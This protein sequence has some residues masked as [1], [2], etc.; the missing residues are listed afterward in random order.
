MPSKVRIPGPVYINQIYRDLANDVLYRVVHTG[1]GQPNTYLVRLDGSRLIVRSI[2]TDEF[3]PLAGLN[4]TATGGFVL[5][6]DPYADLGRGVRAT[7]AHGRQSQT[8][9][10]YIR[11]L[12][13]RDSQKGRHQFVQLL[14][15]GAARA[16]IF[17]EHA[18]KLKV[19]PKTLRKYFLLW[20]Q[21]GMTPR[22]VMSS[23][24]NSGRSNRPG[25]TRRQYE[26]HP[27]RR[28]EIRRPQTMLPSVYRDRV[29]R[30]MAD[31]YFT[32]GQAVWDAGLPEDPKTQSAGRANNAKARGR[33]AA[34]RSTPGGRE[35][36]KRGWNRGSRDRPTAL[37]VVDRANYLLRCER[38]VKNAK[39]EA[40]AVELLDHSAISEEIFRHA[41]RDCDVGRRKR[42][43]MGEAE[44]RTR[45]RTPRGHALQHC[46]GPGH[47][48][49]VDATI[50]DIYLVSCFDRTLV[51]GRP[52]VYFVVDLWSR[53]IV[54]LHVS[55]RP[56]SFEGAALA[57]QNMAS[58]KEEFCAQYG[59][60]ITVDEWPCAHLPVRFHC[61]R[62][63]EYKQS[64]PWKR[65]GKV[66]AVGIDNSA[67]FEPFWRGVIE[68]RFGII[69]L[70]AQR[71]GYGIVEGHRD[72]PRNFNSALDALWTRSEFIRELLRAIHLYHRTPISGEIYTPEEMVTS[73][74][75]NTPLERWNWGVNHSL[76]MLQSCAVD[77][78]RHAVFPEAEATITAAG[79]RVNNAHYTPEMPMD[80]I[81]ATYGRVSRQKVR[82][83][84]NPDEMG[85]IDFSPRDEFPRF[86]NLA[87]TNRHDLCGVTTTEWEQFR[88]LESR[89]ARQAR[90]DNEGMRMVQAL[91]S[92]ADR[93][94]AMQQQDTALQV[95]GRKR[96]DATRVS[97]AKKVEASLEQKSPATP[98]PPNDGKA[99]SLSPAARLQQL[100]DISGSRLLDDPGGRRSR[101]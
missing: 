76:A 29:L 45:G 18:E 81:A 11:D 68:R 80:R 61:D 82:I 69:P 42:H 58:P 35:R 8:N 59:F 62:G 47:V 70:I 65:I 51:V 5:E 85:Q 44:S 27:G 60:T 88:T 32:H 36:G 99:I 16:R 52:T 30:W 17:D 26:H 56:P 71:H 15:A 92:N 97:H 12:V 64:L 77:D 9:C 49:M 37:D 74:K 53:M 10:G 6:D 63:C 98:K 93:H 43:S 28:A 57:L 89:N 34:R 87:G 24:P 33:G 31:R 95:A 50:A 83:L 101:R 39:G 72:A 96:P 55:F 38:L 2:P 54:G 84:Y 41:L 90:Q 23:Y 79:F 14:K 19:Q 1:Y 21:R 78:I 94:R 75:P 13:N 73:G 20:L 100:T 91:N 25:T 48:F 22:A 46:R 7:P 86:A 66:F 4:A 67:A 40:T 3:R